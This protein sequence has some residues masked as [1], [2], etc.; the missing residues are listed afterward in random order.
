MRKGRVSTQAVI[1]AQQ[2]LVIGGF[3]VA[4]GVESLN[5][6]P[7]LW[8]IPLLGKALFT[9]SDNT[10]NR[11]ER[12]FILT[13]RLVGD[14]ID[15][16]RYLPPSDQAHLETAL[17]PLTRRNAPYPPVITRSDIAN[18][19]A[20]LVKGRVPKRFKPRPIPAHTDLGCRTPDELPVE[21]GTYQWYEGPD[22]NVAVL[23]L[24]NRS[25]HRMRLDESECSREH[26]LAVSVWPRA[27]LAPGEKAEV[28]IATRA[29][30]TPE[31]QALPRSSLIPP[32]PRAVR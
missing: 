15:P 1:S 24:H 14:Q 27:W 19:F 10:Q 32:A 30:A 3:H 2:S 25:Q 8:R 22:Y 13:P 31:Q 12:L 11:R 29:L 28:F 26:T 5:R 16:S 23:V 21:P 20:D 17:T 6:V 4:E 18:T 9:S 7:L